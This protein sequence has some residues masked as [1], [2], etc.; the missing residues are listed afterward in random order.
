MRQR[1]DLLP[2]TAMPVSIFW[3]QLIHKNSRFISGIVL[4]NGMLF[5]FMKAIEEGD[6]NDFPVSPKRKLVSFTDFLKWSIWMRSN[7]L[8]VGAFSFATKLRLHGSERS[9]TNFVP[10]KSYQI[11][12]EPQLQDPVHVSAGSSPVSFRKNYQSYLPIFVSTNDK[13]PAQKPHFFRYHAEK[14]ISRVALFSVRADAD[15]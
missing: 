14:E 8:E 9:K 4:E 5:H 2:A 10:S 11:A 7:L 1:K 6:I 13:R 3:K 15:I 12:A